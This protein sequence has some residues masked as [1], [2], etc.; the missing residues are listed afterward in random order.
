MKTKGKIHF[1]NQLAIVRKRKEIAQKQVAAL[2]GH[3]TTDQI[4]R[5]ERGAKVPNLKTALKLGILYKIPIR[6]LLDGYFEACQTEIRRQEKG[7]SNTESSMA[8]PAIEAEFCTIKE[9]LESNHVQNADLDI[10]YSH[11][12][13]LIRRRAE[14]MEHL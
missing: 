3:K 6:I 8:Q 2:L 11:C 12:A 4:S 9:K 1:K 5:Y 14:Q 13:Q 7:L 10:A